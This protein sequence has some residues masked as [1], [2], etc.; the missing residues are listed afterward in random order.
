MLQSRQQIHRNCHPIHKQLKFR[1]GQNQIR[2]QEHTQAATAEFGHN[3]Y[4][5]FTCCSCRCTTRK[6]SGTHTGSNCRIWS[7]SLS[8]L[9]MLRLHVYQHKYGERELWC[10][11]EGS[12]LQPLD[13]ESSLPHS[14]IPP[15]SVV[16]DSNSITCRESSQ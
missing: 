1:S 4:H 16:V 2:H 3:H 11:N 10:L 8:S 13:P 6:T 5:P 9:Y 14:G 15:P 12:N 7:Q